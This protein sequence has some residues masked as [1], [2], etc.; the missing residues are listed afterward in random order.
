MS[1]NINWTAIIRSILTIGVTND[2]P[3][4]V[5]KLGHGS[6]S[7]VRLTVDESTKYVAI[8]ASTSDADRKEEVDVLSQMAIFGEIRLIP[9]VLDQFQISGPHDLDLGNLF[10]QLSSPLDDLSIQPLHERYGQPKKEPVVCLDLKAATS[11]DAS[12]PRYVVPAVWLGILS[13]E[14]TLG[15]AK[16]ILGDFG[17]AFRAGDKSRFKSHVP[18]VPPYQ[19]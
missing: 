15:E 7:T 10:L 5:H 1:V 2:I 12:V 17:V 14:I 11:T 8:K 6:F 3:R 18:I 16:L 9:T 19:G 4:I 13:N